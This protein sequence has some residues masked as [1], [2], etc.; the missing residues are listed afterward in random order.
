[1]YG[2][3]VASDVESGHCE[4]VDTP[5]ESPVG[6]EPASSAKIVRGGICSLS[7]LHGSNR[8]CG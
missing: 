1:V 8:K 3:G 4:L 5:Y 7:G 6:V 2:T